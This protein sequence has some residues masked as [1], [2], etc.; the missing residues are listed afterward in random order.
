MAALFIFV[1]GLVALW[2]LIAFVTDISQTKQAIRRNYPVIGSYGWLDALFDTVLQR[3]IESAPDFIKAQRKAQRVANYVKN[4]THEV[5]TIAHSCGVRN[6]RELR[7][8][9]ARVVQANG[10]SVALDELY[11]EVAP[12][13][14]A[15]M[16]E[17]REGV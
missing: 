9:H 8:F 12:R 4:V 1:V 7:R 13:Q 6:P 14:D 15:Q 16:S 5:G 17:G 10:I 2:A 3:G 11:P